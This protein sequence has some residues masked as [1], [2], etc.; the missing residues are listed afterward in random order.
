MGSIHN[1]RAIEETENNT[2]SNLKCLTRY[3]EESLLI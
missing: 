1:N 3:R 2:R